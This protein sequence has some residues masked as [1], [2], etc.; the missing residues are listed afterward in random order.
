[1][2]SEIILFVIGCF[3]GLIVEYAIR[4]KKMKQLVKCN[5]DLWI[6]NINLKAKLKYGD[7]K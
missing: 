2:I 1:L 5:K 7:K 4:M 3:I 6:D